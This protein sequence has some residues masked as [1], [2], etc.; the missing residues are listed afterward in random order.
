MR[1]HA[2]AFLLVLLVSL[3]TVAQATAIAVDGESPPKERR[4]EIDIGNLTGTEEIGTLRL[5]TR[6]LHVNVGRRFGDLALLAEYDYLGVGR[7]D[8]VTGTLSRVGV[9]AR[10][11]LLR[12]SGRPDDSGRRRSTSGDLW[13]E[14]G[15]GVQRIM[16]DAGGHLVRPDAVLGFGLQLNWVQRKDTPRPRYIGPYIGFRAHLSRGPEHG[17]EVMTDCGAVCDTPSRPSRN[18]VGTFFHLGINWGR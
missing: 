14:G 10:Y 2:A 12:T 18:N 8:D 6:G 1:R 3:P 13:I 16:W 7:D 5:P 15:A 4:T 17:P 9:T 11:S